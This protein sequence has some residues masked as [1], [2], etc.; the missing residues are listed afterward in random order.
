MIKYV[1]GDATR[2]NFEA[3]K[4]VIIPHVC[5]DVGRWGAGFVM[6]I[7]NRCLKP[8]REYR[9]WAKD[10]VDTDYSPFKLGQIQLVNFMGLDS[11][12]FVCNMIAQ[13]DVGHFH[14]TKGDKKADMPPIRYSSLAECMYRI[15]VAIGN[16]TNIE[17]HAPWFGCG[18]AGADKAKIEQMIESIWCDFGGLDVTMYDFEE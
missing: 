1:K 18:L 12:M 5:N 6:A 14:F 15:V 8:E 4:K 11:S 9:Q 16:E 13:R 17:I 2:P 10:G 7:S 3:G